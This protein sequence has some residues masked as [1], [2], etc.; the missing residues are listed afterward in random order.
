V[1]SE[2]EQNYKRNCHL[3]NHVKW[4][5]RIRGKEELPTTVAFDDLDTWLALVSETLFRGLSINADR[6]YDEIRT[7]REHLK[8]DTATLQNA[9]STE[10]VPD[11][12]AKIGMLNREKMVK[13]LDSVTEKIV[14]PTQTDY[15]TVLLFHRETTANLEFPFGKSQTNIYCVRSL[16]PTEIKGLIAD[17]NRLRMLLDQ[18]ITPTQDKE[19]QIKQLERVPE[20]VRDIKELESGIEKERA[21]IG[22]Q[23]EACAA[24]ARE[25]ETEEKRL[26]LLEEG[27]EWLQFKELETTLSSLGT[28]LSELES[29]VHKLF[30]PL[31][32]PLK[33]LKKQHETGRHTLTPEEQ[34]AISSI[35]SSPLRALGGDVK[36]LVCTIK[37][38][39]DEDPSVLKDRKRESALNWIDQL[40][41]SDLT[42][43][44]ENRAVLQ[45][46]MAEVNGKLSDLTIRNEKEEL[47]RALDSVQ[48]QLTQLQDEIA[49]SKKHIV[50]LEEELKK[51][52][53]RLVAALEELAGK[54][55]EV[56]F[57]F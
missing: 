46:H 22:T 57:T 41:N 17:L 11:R 40:L 30:T 25:I 10:E 1:Q 2:R 51:T 3:R 45:A 12:I 54:S 16:F 49:R 52:K 38:I 47:E 23:E 6:L 36:G 39:I 33:L 19:N 15:K 44:K 8:Q 34:G 14:V 24:L 31:N 56:T 13:H 35:L 32:K 37:A 43:I 27:E 20:L 53:Q 28:E 42:S 5:D 26:R 4:L 7:L 18:L 50:S 55:I 21:N 9:E 29:N 48:G